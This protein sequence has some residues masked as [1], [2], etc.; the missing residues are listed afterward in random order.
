VNLATVNPVVQPTTIRGR[1]TNQQGDP[2]VMASVQLQ[3]S[4]ERVYTDAQ[5]DYRLVAVEAGARTVNVSA[6]GF[7]TASQDV[8]VLEAGGEV[9][10]DVSM[11]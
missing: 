5:G 8:S 6:S 9:V 2:L 3:G 11:S 4:G 7:Q 1:I 10:L